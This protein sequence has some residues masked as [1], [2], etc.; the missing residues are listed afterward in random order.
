MPYINRYIALSCVAA[1]IFATSCVNEF[2]EEQAP[3]SGEGYYISLTGDINECG[4]ESRAHWDINSNDQSLAFTWDASDNK[5][6]SFVWSNSAFVNFTDEKKYSATTVTPNAEN[7]K[8]AQLQI[9]TGLSQEYAEGDFIWAVSP[10]EDSNISADNKVTFTLPDQFVQTTLNSTEHLKDYVLMSGTGTVGSDNSASISFKVLPAIYRFKITNNESEDLT[11]NEVSISGPFCNKAVLEY[12]KEP[13]YSVSNGTYAIKVTTPDGGLTVAANTTAYLYALVFPT[14]TSSITEQIELSFK[15]KYGDTAADYTKTAKCSDI[16]TYD[17]N[18][19]TY[20]DLEVPVDKKA[21]VD[22]EKSEIILYNG[23]FLIKGWNG[24]PIS[25]LFLNYL[26]EGDILTVYF[27]YSNTGSIISLRDSKWEPFDNNASRYLTTEEIEQGFF[28]YTLTAAAAEIL[29]GLAQPNLII[30]GDGGFT[31]TKV[32]L[33]TLIKEDYRDPISPNA[34]M[35]ID[36][37]NNSPEGG[38]TGGGIHEYPTNENGNKYL[39][40]AQQLPQTNNDMLVPGCTNQGIGTVQNIENYVIKFDLM[41]EQ[42]TVGASQANLQFVFPNNN[43]LWAGNILP[44]TTEGKWITISYNISN[45][46]NM[47]FNG[48]I[49]GIQ[50]WNVPAGICIDNYRLEPKE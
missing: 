17:L 35:L 47:P 21:G 31:I 22:T 10:L 11:V 32:T 30:Q 14:N 6:K 27:K 1:S 42:G 8:K 29:N 49:N 41:I 2:E 46:G 5:M 13:A 20:Y 40:L 50:G 3:V 45:T 44:E 28:T 38:E 7:K 16:Y 18:S 33:K 4:V 48:Y 24:L 34:L 15:G 12:G 25:N 19:N 37:D 9:T 23:E 39:R 36:F 26:E 43:Y